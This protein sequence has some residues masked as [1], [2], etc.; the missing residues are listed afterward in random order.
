[1][2]LVI[3]LSIIVSILSGSGIVNAEAPEESQFTLLFLENGVWKDYA[4]DEK[5]LDDS[6]KLGDASLLERTVD[7]WH[8][9]TDTD[10]GKKPHWRI[11]DKVEIYD[12]ELGGVD[13][14]YN[15]FNGKMKNYKVDFEFNLPEEVKSKVEAGEKLYVTVKVGKTH[16]DGADEKRRL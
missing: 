16:K 12:S 10:T 9:A 14:Y 5:I 15:N 7:A 13:V 4:G 11:D 8:Y 3:A 6:M 2:G 1:M